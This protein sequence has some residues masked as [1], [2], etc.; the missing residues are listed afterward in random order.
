MKTKFKHIWLFILFLT[1]G[2]SIADETKKNI[3]VVPIQ[4]TIGRRTALPPR[5]PRL[6]PVVAGRR[7]QS[8]GTK[9]S[10]A[11]CGRSSVHVR[12]NY[13]RWRR[14][15]TSSSKADKVHDLV[16]VHGRSIV[17]KVRQVA[18]APTVSWWKM[19]RGSI[20]SLETY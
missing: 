20:L 5:T 4:D 16:E 3:Y 19:R 1:L 6:C 11:L 10:R 7:C 13:A 8:F 12:P 15:R 2:S 17:Q 9:P 18:Q 14:R